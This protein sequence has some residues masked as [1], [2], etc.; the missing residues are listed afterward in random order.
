M[1]VRDLTYF[2]HTHA[3]VL[4]EQNYPLSYRVIDVGCCRENTTQRRDTILQRA[5]C[6]IAIVMNNRI[7]EDESTLSTSLVFIPSRISWPERSLLGRPNFW[8]HETMPVSD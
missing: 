3:Y 5:A 4:F 6:F 8:D 2:F 1:G 7:T